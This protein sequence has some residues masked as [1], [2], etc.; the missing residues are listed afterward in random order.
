MTQQKDEPAWKQDGGKPRMDL[1]APEFLFGTANVLTYGAKKYS[2]EVENEWHGLLLADHVESLRLLTPE[3]CA[4]SVM[5]ST[6][7]RPILSLQSASGRT[8]ETGRQETQIECEN[9]QNAGVA[10]LK[11]AHGISGLNGASPF[12]SMGFL[13]GTTNDF[14]PQAALFVAQSGTCTLTIATTLGAFEVSFAPAAI[15]DLGF[16]TTVWQD[17]NARFGISRPRSQTGE[18]NWEKGMSWGRV[19]G[20]MMRH[21]WAWWGG[22]K[23][24]DETG[25]SHL[26]HAACCLMFLIAYEERKI[27]TDDRRG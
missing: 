25:Y 26:H 27:G 6:C 3:G 15:T 24:D 23:A 7:G 13:N 10:I 17:L 9:W 21:M 5:K 22:Q 19:F 1:I 18:R 16:W 4:V 2:F 8:G 20:A 14:A 12:A 11:L